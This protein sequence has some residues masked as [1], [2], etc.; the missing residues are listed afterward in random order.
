MY[1]DY[2][3]D[4]VLQARPFRVVVQ[5]QFAILFRAAKRGRP[6]AWIQG[7]QMVVQG[8]Q[9]LFVFVFVVV[10]VVVFQM[11]SMKMQQKFNFIFHYDQGMGIEWMTMSVRSAAC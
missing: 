7:A 9:I 11:Y 8:I 1:L 4:N 6:H 5:Q 2:A 10:F 3:D